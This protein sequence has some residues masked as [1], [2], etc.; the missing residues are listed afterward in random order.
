MRRPVYCASHPPDPL[1][2]SWR[3]WSTC[4]VCRRWPTA[5]LCPA[6]RQRWDQPILRCSHCADHA[7]ATD[8]AGHACPLN[9][10]HLWREAAARMDYATPCDQW[11]KRLKFGADWTQ[12]RDL[13]RL[14]NECAPAQ[15]LRAQADL[16]LPMP[17]SDT[18]LRERGYNQAALLARHWCGRDP[19]LHIDWL[20]KHRHTPAQAQADRAQR[21]QQLEG[22]LSWGAPTRLHKL[23]GARVLL[24]DDVM[25]T[26][27]TLDIASSVLLQ[28]G[29]AQVDVVVFARTPSPLGAG[30]GGGLHSP[31][32][33]NRPGPP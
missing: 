33:S 32:V 8:P 25:T 5:I 22:T 30:P 11:I 19:R 29:V 23:R 20:I 27:A 9:P 17:I 3:H 13:A 2:M 18:R 1:M 14:L 7:H 6:C 28:T 31:H 21:L 16:I 26:G 12:A 4:K 10:R 24:V 15:R